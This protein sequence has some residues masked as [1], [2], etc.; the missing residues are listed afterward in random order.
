MYWDNYKGVCT[1]WF[2]VDV[3]V[4]RVP[5]MILHIIHMDMVLNSKISLM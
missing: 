1:L 5:N 4:P 3:E 2:L